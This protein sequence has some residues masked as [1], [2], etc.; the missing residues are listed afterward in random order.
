MFS[1]ERG[2]LFAGLRVCLLPTVCV[3]FLWVTRF[4]CAVSLLLGGGCG[5]CALLLGFM[6]VECIVLRWFVSSSIRLC[7]CCVL[8]AFDL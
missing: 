4:A 1:L 8:L 7:C 2:F 6:F 5:A 3:G